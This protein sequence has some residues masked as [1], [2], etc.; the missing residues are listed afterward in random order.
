MNPWRPPRPRQCRSCWQQFAVQEYPPGYLRL[1]TDVEH[2]SRVAI[3]P[4]CQVSRLRE[5]IQEIRKAD[6]NRPLDWKRIQEYEEDIALLQT[7]QIICERHRRRRLNTHGF[8]FQPMA[9]TVVSRRLIFSR[10]ALPF[11]PPTIFVRDVR[12]DV[13]STQSYCP[14]DID[15]NVDQDVII[16]FDKPIVDSISND[17]AEG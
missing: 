12:N 5:A 4:T 3:C 1:K 2:M 14:C 15:R 6:Y 13:K 8:Q 10:P 7:G 9:A 17:Y 16:L 11:D